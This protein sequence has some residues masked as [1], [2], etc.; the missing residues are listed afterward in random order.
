MFTLNK[1]LLKRTEELEREKAKLQASINSINAGYII[2][3]SSGEIETINN[4]AKAL[5]C[6]TGRTD[7]A[8]PELVKLTCNMGDIATQLQSSLDIREEVKKVL[9]D[10]KP[11][12][13]KDLEYK[14]FFLNIY[15]TP[16]VLLQS[17]SSIEFIGTVI[18]VDDVTEAKILERSRQDFFSIASHELKTPLTVIKGNAEL[19]KTYFKVK[20]EKFDK[21]ID[22]I[23]ESAE[24]LIEIV[25]DFLDISHLEQGKIEFKQERIELV[26]FVNEVIESLKYMADKKH[27]SLQAP[28]HTSKLYV[29]ADEGRAKQVLIN[30][31]G[32]A[33]KFTQVGGVDISFEVLDKQV[34]ILVKDT[35]KGISSKNQQLVFRKFELAT[36]EPLN[37]DTSR[38]TGVGLYIS[39][40]LAEGMRGEVKLVSSEEGKG[41]VFSFTLPTE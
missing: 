23:H 33:V 40:F 9:T 11:F 16:I 22:D 18:L 39:K 19:I 21:I 1:N 3:D 37:R 12:T 31:I 30:L 38:S 20:N 4:A 26:K 2:T 6:T 29:I 15:I 24:R 32:N 36:S 13:I 5:F 35:G 28:Q 7:A 25:S 27:I 34:V 14:N 8:N 41:S 17:K 10:K